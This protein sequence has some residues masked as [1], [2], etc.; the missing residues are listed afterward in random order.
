[1]LLCIFGLQFQIVINAALGFDTFLV[2]RHGVKTTGVDTPPEASRV[3]CLTEGLPGSHL[4]C[5]FCND[6]VAPGN[7]SVQFYLVK[8]S[9]FILLF[10]NLT[11]R[12]GSF[13]IL[14]LSSS[15]G[16]NKVKCTLFP[17]IFLFCCFQ[18]MRD[19]TLDQQCTVT[20]PGVSM[21]AGALAVELLVSVLQHP[22][23]CV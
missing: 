10:I 21:V 2:L 8:M 7:V 9:C 6:V 18:S 3:T 15:R 20:R 17:S 4:G 1:M 23:G 13:S 5:Y 11:K 14:F 22:K 19:R 12:K 16:V